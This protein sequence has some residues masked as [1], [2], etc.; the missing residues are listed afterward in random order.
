MMRP[1]VESR[2]WSDGGCEWGGLAAA[3]EKKKEDETEGREET[4]PEEGLSGG[5]G[6]AL[7][8]G[9]DGCDGG[10]SGGLAVWASERIVEVL[11]VIESMY[12][13]GG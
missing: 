7:E 3:E 4:E 1:C 10:G 9:E 11:L 6:R 8:R 5:E 2:A 13:T 12:A